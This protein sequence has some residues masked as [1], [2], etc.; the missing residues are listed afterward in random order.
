MHPVPQQ[1]RSR[2][3]G[4]PSPRFLSPAA[5]GKVVGGLGGGI[6]REEKSCHISRYRKDRR[7]VGRFG[8]G[9]EAPQRRQ[10]VEKLLYLH[11]SLA[12]LYSGGCGRRL[13]SSAGP[14]PARP[15]ANCTQARAAGLSLRLSSPR[16]GMER[17][18]RNPLF[19]LSVVVTS[20]ERDST[21]GGI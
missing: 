2:E 10:K 9:R 20:L 19:S 5:G 11:L 16:L 3:R 18:R 7:S 13:S 15:P 14:P 12:G 1:P 6:G 8:R 17:R 4:G 21:I